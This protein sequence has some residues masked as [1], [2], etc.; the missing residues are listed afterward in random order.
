MH[1]FETIQSLTVCEVDWE[2]WR[3]PECGGE[4][5]GGRTRGCSGRPD[6]W[7]APGPGAC[8]IGSDLRNRNI[9]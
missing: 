4:G 5:A 2:G 1:F 3:E 8:W 7:T 9:A 6:P